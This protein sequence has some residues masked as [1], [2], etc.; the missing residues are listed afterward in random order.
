MHLLT[1]PQ[2][3]QQQIDQ[4]ANAGKPLARAVVQRYRD[5]QTAALQSCVD[6]YRVACGA[7]HMVVKIA[8]AKLAAVNPAAAAAAADKGREREQ[9]KR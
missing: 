5:E 2:S 9:P 7:E 4:A 8:L 3:L 6:T 1:R